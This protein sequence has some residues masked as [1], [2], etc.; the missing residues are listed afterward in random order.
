METVI[1]VFM[2]QSDSRWECN[3]GDADKGYERNIVGQAMNHLLRA[4]NNQGSVEILE[5]V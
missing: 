5:G 1:K 3:C 2:R 4:H